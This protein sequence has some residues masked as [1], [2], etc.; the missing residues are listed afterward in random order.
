MWIPKPIYEKAP[1]FWFL[2]GIFSIAAALYIGFDYKPT[3]YY[4]G[5]G[6]FCCGY[7]AAILTLRMRYRRNAEASEENGNAAE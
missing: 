3:T 7:G 6:F 1:H 2:A 5:L 4:I